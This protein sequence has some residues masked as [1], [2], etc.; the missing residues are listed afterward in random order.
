MKEQKQICEWPLGELLIRAAK[1]HTKLPNVSS[2]KRFSLCFAKSIDGELWLA[3]GE[4]GVIL[5]QK[6]EETLP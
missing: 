4:S 6:Q 2:W 3:A 5:A 1:I